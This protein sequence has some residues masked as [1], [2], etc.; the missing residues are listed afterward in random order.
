MS[1]FTRN[2]SRLDDPAD[3]AADDA[4]T[5][6]RIARK[7]FARRQWARRWLAWR[8][9]V[10]GLLVVGLLAGGVWLVFFS[11][12]LAVAGVQV[13]GN[14][15]LSGAAVRRAAAVPIG[16][17]LATVDLG[18][19]TARV[20]KLPAVKSVDVSRAWPDRVRVDV[21]ERQAVAVVDAGRPGGQLRG[22]DAGGVVFGHHASRP[23]HL[24]MIRRGERTGSD[25]LAEAATVAGSLPRSLSGTVAYV[26]VRTVDRISV[27]LRN[28]RTVLW[29]S[30]DDSVNKARVLSVLLRQPAAVYDVTVPGQPVIRK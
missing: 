21:T 16:A 1:L 24:P 2:A 28:G 3:G 27:E 19:V 14:A 9:V 4:E 25:A 30:A 18:S 5:T 6:I 12:V 22:I 8:R 15:E 26:E 20:R 29:G 7:R 23:Q 13:E 10:V 17:P 11:S